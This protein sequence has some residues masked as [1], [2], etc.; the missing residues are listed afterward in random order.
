[1]DVTLE[2]SPGQH[3]MT[4]DDVSGKRS[5]HFTYDDS[6]SEA[7][8]YAVAWLTGHDPSDLKPL[9]TAIDPDALDELV[10]SADGSNLS[11]EFDYEGCMVTIVGSGDLYIRPSPDLNHEQRDPTSAV[12]LLDES[13]D[14]ST[15]SP[16]AFPALQV[17]LED[18]DTLAVTFS[19]DAAE[20]WRDVMAPHSADR[21]INSRILLAG[22]F[23]RSSGTPPIETVPP[24]NDV[25]L[26]TVP[27]PTNLTAIDL[28]ISHFLEESESTGNQ[29]VVCFQSIGDLLQHVPL[30]EAS[31]FFNSILRRVRITGAAAY[32]YLDPSAHDEQTRRTL[33]SLFDIV[34]FRTT[35][36]EWVVRA[37]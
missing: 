33:E 2:D 26:D 10:E 34:A 24:L 31:G 6:P 28:L 4:D 11:V 18:T 22:D 5:Y 35:D 20:E 13:L 19:A 8:I 29:T 1:M 36:G 17:S 15:D 37:D 32:F 27:D 23:T 30:Q 14:P 7:T 12:L 9:F 21:S 16:E 3:T 25:Q